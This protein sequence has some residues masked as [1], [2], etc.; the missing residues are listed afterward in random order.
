MRLQIQFIAPYAPRGSAEKLRTGFHLETFAW[1]RVAIIR[2]AIAIAL[3]RI[4][5][6][7]GNSL[8]SFVAGVSFHKETG[9]MCR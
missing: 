5:F 8:P 7:Y 6:P 2:A 4:G 9:Q 3:L 1:L